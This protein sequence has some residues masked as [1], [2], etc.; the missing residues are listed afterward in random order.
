MSIR[1]ILDS[2]QS[3][4]EITEEQVVKLLKTDNYSPEFYDLICAANKMSRNEYQN[5]GFVFAQIG[6]N[7]EPC[8]KNCRFCSM[9]ENHYVVESKWRK[10]ANALEKE[11]GVLAD[12]DVSDY[13]LMTTADYPVHQF[14]NLARQVR[15]KIS[16]GK[17]FVANIGDFD[18]DT[19]AA[20]KDAGFTGVYH[21]HRLREGID[22]SIKPEERI[23]TLE[24][25]KTVGLELY[26]CVEPIGP[27]HSYE[28]IAAE[29]IRA[30]YYGVEVMAVMRRI[31]VLGTPLFAK[32]QISALELTKIAAVTRLVCKPRR[33]MNAHEPTQM[34][35]LAGVN[36][37][38]A[39][40][41]ANPRDRMSNTENCRGFSV[42][43]AWRMLWEAGY[44]K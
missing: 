9:G 20:L 43:Q 5:R 44:R 29:I 23:K 34:T 35:L 6:I 39:E 1:K 3:G 36:Q 37:L 14:L 10:D 15:N 4:V 42:D 25:I 12:Q 33:A 18:R 19:A 21:I 27:E 22:T 2:A 31:P 24:A 11:L 17:R 41:G 16:K 28:E 7:A 13:F 38:Y 32:G 40:S 8:S 26:Y 30:R